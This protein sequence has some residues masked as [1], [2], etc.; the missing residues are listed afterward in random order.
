MQRWIASL[1]W[2]CFQCGFQLDKITPQLS[3]NR[4]GSSYPIP[5]ENCWSTGISRFQRN[6]LSKFAIKDIQAGGY[7]LWPDRNNAAQALGQHGRAPQPPH[8]IVLQTSRH[9]QAERVTRGVRYATTWETETAS[10]WTKP[11]LFRTTMIH[12]IIIHQCPKCTKCA[13]STISPLLSIISWL[14]LCNHHLLP[15]SFQ[16]RCQELQLRHL[17]AAMLRHWSWRSPFPTGKEH[18]TAI[19]GTGDFHPGISFMWG[20]WR[21]L[22][23]CKVWCNPAVEKL[24]CVVMFTCANQVGLWK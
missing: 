16:W 20:P 8:L 1:P 17:E 22:P 6:L 3:H 9:A 24:T 23:Q 12:I 4:K 7:P 13:L 15:F 14:S 18:G 21:F 11:L 19:P 2:K 10:E 5:V